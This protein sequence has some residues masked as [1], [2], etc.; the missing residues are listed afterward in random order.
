MMKHFRATKEDY[1]TFKR[2]ESQVYEVVKAWHNLAPQLLKEKYK[3]AEEPN[4]MFHFVSLYTTHICK[5]V[6]PTLTIQ[7]NVR[8]FRP[9]FHNIDILGLF[10]TPRYLKLCIDH[11]DDV[12]FW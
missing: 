3:T 5:E 7:V 6:W 8:F 12:V 11:N 10:A 1:D 4:N 9:C 2:A